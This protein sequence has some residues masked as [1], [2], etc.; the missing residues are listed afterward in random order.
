MEINH[1]HKHNPLKKLYFF[2]LLIARPRLTASII[3]GLISS[4]ILPDAI[5][6]RTITRSIIGWNIGVCLYLG[7]ALRMMF[8]ATKEKIQ[9]SAKEQDEG[10]V[11]ILI[12]VLLSVASTL[13]SIVV[14]LAHI[15]NLSVQ[16][17]YV[18]I[19]LAAFSI[20]TSWLF[21]HLMFAI[22]YAHDYYS[23]I[24][25]SKKGGIIFPDEDAPDYTDFL[26]LAFIIGTS[27]QTADVSFSSKQ[28]RK[29]ALV[30]CIFA[31]FFN[32]TLL[33]LT[34]NIASSFF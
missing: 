12:M 31:F 11:L 20:T 17:R 7:L 9:T 3:I 21:A 6:Q 32:T 2:R 1:P 22:H 25:N 5:A 27:A 10:Q 23:A 4:F 30:H 24:S 29:T 34:I 13:T 14:E 26:Y 18:H 16:L 19:A 33:A 8:R 28:M 15:K